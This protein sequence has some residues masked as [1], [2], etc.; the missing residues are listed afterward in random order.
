MGKN[1]RLLILFGMVLA[2]ASFY[3][4][5][6]SWMSSKEKP[7]PPQ[8]IVTPLQNHQSQKNI[9]DQDEAQE[10]K[11]DSQIQRAEQDVITKVIQDNKPQEKPQ[12]KLQETT[13]SENKQTKSIEK[14]EEPKKVHT[15][16]QK[17]Q[18]TKNATPESEQTKNIEKQKEPDKVYTVQ[19]GAFS[20]KENAMKA[21]DKAK[22]MGYSAYL[23]EEESFYKVLIKIQT[24]DIDSEL[25]KLRVTFGGAILR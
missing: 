13:A 17:L 16:Q 18:E 10:Y 15:V 3:M 5:L 2:L 7:Q 14:Q 23:K 11:I 4:G 21:I 22:S 1:K 9:P 6:K 25:K 12:Q 8:V 19:I 24:N 20:Y